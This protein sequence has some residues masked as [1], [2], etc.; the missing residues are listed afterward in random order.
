LCEEF[1]CRPSQAL[2]EWQQA[3]CDLLETILEF[4]AYAQAKHVV[5]NAK[6]RTD[7]PQ[8]PLTQLVQEIEFEIAAED[9]EAQRRG[10][11]D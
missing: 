9:I 1:H 10:K 6:S 2:R 7:I 8:T 11:S 5:E 3:P 4:R